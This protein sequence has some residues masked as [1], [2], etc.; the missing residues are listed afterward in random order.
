MPLPIPIHPWIDI[1]MDFILRLP[2][3]RKGRD[4]I[5]VIVDRFSKITHFIACHKTKD[6]THIVDLFL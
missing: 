4:C 6:A 3:T 5:F 1:S 2:R